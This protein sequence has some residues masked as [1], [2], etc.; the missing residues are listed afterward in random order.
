MNFVT[1]E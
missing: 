1:R